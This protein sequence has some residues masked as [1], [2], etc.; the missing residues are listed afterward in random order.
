MIKGLWDRET[1][2]L[3]L[4]AAHLPLAGFWMAYAGPGAVGRLALVVLLLAIWQLVFLLVRAQPASLASGV[5]AL[6]IAMLAPDDLG[7]FQLILGTSFGTVVGELIFGGWGRNLVPP[8]TVALSFLGFGFPGLGWPEFV[9]PVAWAA[10]PAAGIG[11]LFGILRIGVLIGAALPLAACLGAGLLPLATVQTAGMV[12]VLLVADPATSG[13]TP[14]GR[15]LNGLLY[16]GLVVLFATGWTGAADVQLCIAAALLTALAVP[17]L[18]EAALALWYAQR[19]RRH[20]R[21]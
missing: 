1:V 9:A 6:A 2:A 10:L 21:S 14:L 3:V 20:V 15:R 7:A 13:T 17:L 4:V 18:D 11:L 16:A 8:A 19:R 5:T 12:L